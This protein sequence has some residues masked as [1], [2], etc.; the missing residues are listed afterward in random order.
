MKEFCI[1]FLNFKG[2]FV[3]F[4]E[5]WV[6]FFIFIV[7]LEGKMVI[8]GIGRSRYNR[9][10]VVKGE[11][12]CVLEM[13]LPLSAKS[14]FDCFISEREYP[15]SN[16]SFYRTNH[17]LPRETTLTFGTVTVSGSCHLLAT[18]FHLPQR[19]LSVV[20]RASRVLCFSK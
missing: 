10:A 14:D 19:V 9:P 7:K 1:F 5:A 3:D 20:T 12:V 4:V 2:I 16:V 17:Y 11:T 8:F 18:K 6:V 15:M 13:P